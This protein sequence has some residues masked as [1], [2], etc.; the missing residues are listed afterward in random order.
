MQAHH[1][2]DEHQRSLASLS[3]SNDTD[4]QRGET[5]DLLQI[6]SQRIVSIEHPCIIRDIDKGVKSLGGET[7]VRN[8]SGL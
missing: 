1:T 6:P 7:Q 3:Q 2:D 4:E 8:V 5:V